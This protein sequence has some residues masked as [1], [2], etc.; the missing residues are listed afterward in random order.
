MCKITLSPKELMKSRYEAFLREDW[1]YIEKTSLYQKAKD[2]KDM[3]SIEWVNLEILDFYDDIVE[4]KAY[5]KEDASMKVLHEKS[6]FVKIDKEWKYKDGE[7]FN[8]KI[9]R[10]QSCPCGSTKK[11]KKC[12][13]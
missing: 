8:S 7:I 9:H 2:L 10:N 12:C 11:F 13:Y 1:D 4:F 5:Y 3:A 6:S